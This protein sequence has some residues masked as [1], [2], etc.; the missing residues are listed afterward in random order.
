MQEFHRYPFLDIHNS[1]LGKTATPL[2]WGKEL[3]KTLQKHMLIYE[4]G[5]KKKENQPMN[6][7]KPTMSP[8]HQQKK[9]KQ[10]IYGQKNPIKLKK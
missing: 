9:P 10:E 6:Q 3:Y 5:G 4:L 1:Q 8:P 7:T 2:T